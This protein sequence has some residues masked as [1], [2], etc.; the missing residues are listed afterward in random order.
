[1]SAGTLRNYRLL[2]RSGLRV[3]PLALGT[4]TFGTDWGWG[5]DEREARRI[6]D[7][8]VEL[9]GNLVDTAN[10]Y[11]NGTAEQYIGKFTAERRDSLVIATKYT[12]P[13]RA[14]DPNSGGNHRKSMKTSIELSLRNLR[15]DYLDMLFLHLWDATTASDEILRAMDDLV[16]AGKVLYLGISNTPAWRVA[17]MQ[18]IA[19]LRGWA[20]LVAVQ[21]EYSLIERGAERDLMPMAHELGLGVMTWAPLGDGILTGRYSKSDLEPKHAGSA[22]VPGRREISLARGTLT[23][24]TLA[25]ADVVKSVAGEIGKSPSQVA[26]AWTLQNASVTAPIVGARTLKQLHDSLGALEL[27]FTKEQQLR[28]HQASAVQL[29]YP[30]DYLRWVMRSEIMSTCMSGA[31]RDI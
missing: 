26:L 21:I 24:R 23:Q 15:T 2:G 17:G 4:M 19:D 14:G 5:A 28:L 9:G 22:V 20:P 3:S 27:Q 16:R 7:R 1:M 8:Y 13:T 18:A 10:L 12:L 31:S 30:H 29:G 11:T 25:I 6:F